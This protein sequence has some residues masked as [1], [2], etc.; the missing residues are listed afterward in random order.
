MRIFI[1][2]LNGETFDLEVD[3]LDSIDTV[4]QKIHNKEGI[5]CNNYHLIFDRHSLENKQS[6]ND[7][8]IKDN[9]EILLIYSIRSDVKSS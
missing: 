1:R 9:C 3:P 8:N 6:L 4:R 7:Y 5:P 2:Y